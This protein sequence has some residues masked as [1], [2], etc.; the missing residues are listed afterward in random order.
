MLARNINKIHQTSKDPTPE[1]SA[2]AEASTIRSSHVD[3]R[4]MG[5]VISGVILFDEKYAW[6]PIRFH[7][8]WALPVMT[9]LTG[10]GPTTLGHQCRHQA[11]TIVQDVLITALQALSIQIQPQHRPSELWAGPCCP[12]PSGRPRRAAHPTRAHGEDSAQGLVC[13]YLRI[14]YRY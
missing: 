8:R 2:S 9:V 13:T 10:S 5:N 7:D 4:R 14:A 11:S 3:T 12:R 6:V 1:Q